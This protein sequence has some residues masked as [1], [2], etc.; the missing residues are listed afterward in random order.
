MV[1]VVPS[2]EGKEAN[3]MVHKPHI[4]AGMHQAIIITEQGAMEAGASGTKERLH[5]PTTPHPSFSIMA[6]DRGDV[7]E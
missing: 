2:L 4:S 6:M 5:D 1:K 3:T 7:L